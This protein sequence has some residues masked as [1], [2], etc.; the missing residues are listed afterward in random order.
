M[1]I[2]LFIRSDAGRLA[3][4]TLFITL[5]FLSAQAATFTVTKTADTNDGTCD[6]DC[7]L[8]EAI[9]AATAS[10]LPENTIS[11]DP[12][13]FG[14]PQ[15][16]LL[17]GGSLNILGNQSYSIAGTGTDLLTIDCG[18]SGAVFVSVQATAAISALKITGNVNG[19]TGRIQSNGN[20][21]IT[22]VS[23]TNSANAIGIPAI[24][25]TG[26][27]TVFNSSVTNNPRTGVTNQN[28][29]LT[30][31]NSNISNNN[32]GGIFNNG[33]NLD[34]SGSTINSNRPK[35]IHNLDGTANVTFSQITNNSTH[36]DFNDDGVGIFNQFTGAFP[37]VL[38]IF[39]SEISG[40][41]SNGMNSDGG[42]IA[43]AG[44]SLTIQDSSIN[45]NQVNN[46]NGGGIYST[47]SI[48]ATNV[49]YIRQQSRIKR[50]RNLR[51]RRCR[52]VK[53]DRQL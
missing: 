19:I 14:S 25:N 44:G 17:T 37:A 48:I 11:F 30:V 15:T 42:G 32:G 41:S 36:N 4:I 43:N 40:N 29:T 23:V 16:I 2:T 39:N 8:R 20:L 34:V 27:L 21:T 33:G 45:N 46:G 26:T 28:G 22:N 18:H 12:V 9:A 3:V 35:G 38:S 50:R 6:A 49:S 52:S 24:M 31:V 53:R 7:S 51:D 10:G 47:N 13:V 5:S 1:N